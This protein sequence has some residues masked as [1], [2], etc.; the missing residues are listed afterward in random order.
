MGWFFIF[1]DFFGDRESREQTPGGLL[2]E[3]SVEQ[4]HNCSVERVANSGEFA[5][6]SGETFT[7][8]SR[9][10][11]MIDSSF[12][13]TRRVHLLS[14]SLPYGSGGCGMGP[15]VRWVCPFS[16]FSGTGIFDFPGPLGRSTLV[17]FMITS[18]AEDD[19]RVF[20]GSEVVEHGAVEA[21]LGDF[22]QMKGCCS[23]EGRKDF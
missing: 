12:L 23:I 21:S 1:D 15:H 3:Y 19:I 4:L 17:P 5:E 6:I 14:E 13:T 20:P 22:P 2:P 11:K 18:G 9:D 16:C 7:G 10:I 8:D